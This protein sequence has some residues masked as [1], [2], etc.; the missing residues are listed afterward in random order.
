LTWEWDGKGWTL[1]TPTGD[2]PSARMSIA[3][4]FDRVHGEAIVHGGWT[5]PDKPQAGT[6]T[7]NLATHV[8]TYRGAN[9]FNIGCYAIGYD[10]DAQLVRMFGGNIYSTFY[11]DLRSWDESTQTWSSV[12]PAGPSARITAWAYDQAH[13]RFVMFGGLNDFSGFVLSDTWEYNPTAT[14]WQQTAT[15]TDHPASNTAMI[16]E[17]VVYDPKRA[18]TVM[19][20]PTN[21]GETWEYNAGTHLWTKVVGANQ[22]GA[23][24][25]AVVF[26]DEKLEAVLLVGGCA[27][28]ALQN[29]T[30]QY[31]PFL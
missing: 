2:I 18:V 4:A 7:Y 16:H 5:P 1:V 20:L 14:T 29:G 3:M 30:W 12:A 15:T 31:I 8:W 23:T 17:P 24:S 11:R 6:Y 22:I 10:T 19:Y 21:G 26:Y 27:A 9:L 25:E 28:G 13:Q